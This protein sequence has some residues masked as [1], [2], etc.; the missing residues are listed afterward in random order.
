VPRTAVDGAGAGAGRGSEEAAPANGARERVLQAAYELFSRH[1]V[2]AVG[3]D[4]II[5]KAGVA[6]MSFYRH[7]PS[8]DELVLAFLARREDLWTR[9]WLEGE[10]R[11]RAVL[12]EDQLLAIFEVFDGWFH[13]D[14]FEGC[15]FIN[16]L[17]EVSEPGHPIREAS[18][19]HL[20]AIRAFIAELAQK[21][22]I[23]DP[24]GFARKWHILMKGSIVSAGEGDALAARRARDVGALLLASERADISAPERG[25]LSR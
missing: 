20:S 9:A 1:G 3:V 18:V 2:R 12:P 4:T 23:A 5:E 24:D 17:L 15:S 8:K 19:T 13:R 25:D 14:D 10:V 16:T 11:S 22:G 6:K 7:F 21:S